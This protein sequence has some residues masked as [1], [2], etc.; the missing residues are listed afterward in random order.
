MCV[1]ALAAPNCEAF[2]EFA[3]SGDWLGFGYLDTHVWRARAVSATCLTCFPLSSV[4]AI[5]A[6]EPRAKE[7]LSDAIEREFAL[8][9]RAALACDPPTPSSGSRRSY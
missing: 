3:Y 2:L 6:R 4:D 7:K 5:I 1:Y 9:R 8:V